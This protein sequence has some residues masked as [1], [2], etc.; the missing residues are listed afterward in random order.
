[1]TQ[2]QQA[3]PLAEFKELDNRRYGAFREKRGGAQV[4]RRYQEDPFERSLNRNNLYF[5][6]QGSS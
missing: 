5:S 1:M 4:N 6:Q 3:N 2:K